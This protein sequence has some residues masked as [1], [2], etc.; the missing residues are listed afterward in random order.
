M[1]TRSSAQIQD[2]S[3][4]HR[5]LGASLPPRILDYHETQILDLPEGVRLRQSSVRPASGT[6]LF[7][8][9]TND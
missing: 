7:C 1:R 8:E 6:L 2:R 4:Y 9:T 5:N 3:L